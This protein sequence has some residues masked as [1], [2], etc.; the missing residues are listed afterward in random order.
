[1]IHVYKMGSFWKGQVLVYTTGL[2]TDTADGSERQTVE[3]Y[4]C[5]FP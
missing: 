1:M 5:V 2:M 4:M 3:H